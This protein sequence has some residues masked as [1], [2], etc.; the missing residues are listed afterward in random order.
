VHSQTKYSIIRALTELLAQENRRILSD[1]RAV[2]LLRRATNTIPPKNRRWAKAPNSVTAIHPILARLKEAG[3]LKSLPKLSYLYKVTTPYART[4]PIEES[5]ILME[6]HPFATLSY[7]SAFVFHQMTDDL[8]KEIHATIPDEGTGGMLPPGTTLTDWEGLAMVR[9]RPA[10]AISKQ[11]IRWHRLAA[12][13]IFGAH[14]YT[15]QGYPV[16]VT[17][18]ERTLLD[19]LLHPEWSGGIEKVL[20]AWSLYKDLLNVEVL[21]EYVD[22]LGIGVLRQR[23]GFILEELGISP[24]AI[25][26]WPEQA[27]RGGSSKLLGSA[28]FAPTFNERWKL[29]INA[30]I[31]ALY[32]DSS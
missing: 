32:E 13:R 18:P 4:A 10:E 29:S 1:W 2:V 8:P 3:E 19:G 14:E 21:I 20:R 7:I 15:T 30:P 6:L 12:A 24:A 25:H 31:D 23:V 16:R 22:L 5:E 17:T 9:G 11:P 26:G 28:P 27:V